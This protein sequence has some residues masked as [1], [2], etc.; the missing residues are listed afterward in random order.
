MDIGRH[1]YQL[2][3]LDTLAVYALDVCRYDLGEYV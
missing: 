1:A 2:Q 3:E